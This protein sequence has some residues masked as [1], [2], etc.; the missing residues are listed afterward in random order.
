MAAALAVG[1]D[2]VISHRS[3]ADLWGLLSSAT[4]TLEVSCPRR[5]RPSRSPT[6]RRTRTLTPADRTTVDGIPATTVARTLLDLADVAPARHVE[7]ALDQ[8]E[9]L[10][11]FDLV[12]VHDVLARAA[13][14]RGAPALRAALDAQRGGPTFT[15]SGLEEAFLALV[16]GAGLPTPRTSAHVC[17]FEVDVHW[18]AHG[19]VVGLDSYTYHRTRRAF[20][21]DRCRDIALQAA[22]LRT[23][24]F[25][26]RRIAHDPAGVLDD[27]RNLLVDSARGRSP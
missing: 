19:V 18:P 7:R 2:A 15:R 24:R 20:E 16:R 6:V 1:R 13:G 27:V 22:G 21:A 25:T 8:A 26:D 11:L 17:G 4:A 5:C 14:R 3:A 10:R 9:V 12:A 23:A